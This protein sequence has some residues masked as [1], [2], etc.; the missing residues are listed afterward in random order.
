MVDGNGEIICFV[1]MGHT[2]S[3][4]PHSPFLSLSLLLPTLYPSGVDISRTRLMVCRQVLLKYQI[5][6]HNI[7]TSASSSSPSMTSSSSSPSS[8]WCRLLCADGCAFQTGP[9]AAWAGSEEDI[10]FDSRAYDWE[11]SEKSEKKGGREGG[12]REGGRGGGGGGGVMLE[13]IAVMPH[14]KCR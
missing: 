14:R 8:F 3:C 6:R 12:G 7:T 4:H 5:G 2:Q 10:L 1:G 11:V 9:K 13:V